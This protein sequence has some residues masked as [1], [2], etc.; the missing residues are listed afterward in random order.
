MNRGWLPRENKGRGFGKVFVF[1]KSMDLPNPRPWVSRA[2]RVGSRRK[3]QPLLPKENPPGAR[4]L[5]D[6]YL[7]VGMPDVLT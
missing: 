4:L 1:Q 2:N 7:F 3:G 5:G 6:F